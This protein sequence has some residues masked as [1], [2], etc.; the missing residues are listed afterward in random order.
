MDTVLVMQPRATGGKAVL[1]P[2][3]IV[4]AQAIAFGKELP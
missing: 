4:T 1:T 3:E 2:E